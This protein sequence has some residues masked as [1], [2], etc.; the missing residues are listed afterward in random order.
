MRKW[1]KSSERIFW[2]HSLNSVYCTA[3]YSCSVRDLT[4][5][6]K[7]NW[8][9]LSL[10]E[11]N[12]AIHMA[13]NFGVVIKDVFTEYNVICFTMNHTKL[14]YNCV[15][16]ETIQT[17]LMDIISILKLHRDSWDKQLSLDSPLATSLIYEMWNWNVLGF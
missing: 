16:C 2:I 10:L 5:C 8:K 3:I 11:T 12:N 17:M 4:I 1:E 6:N 14:L 9:L 13:Y 15:N 7:S